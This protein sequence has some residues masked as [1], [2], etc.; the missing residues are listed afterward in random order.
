MR[1]P[2]RS[3][4]KIF[5]HRGPY[6]GDD[7]TYHPTLSDACT[8]QL[9]GYAPVG[10]RRVVSRLAEYH[11]V[12]RYLEYLRQLYQHR[13]TELCVSCFDMTHM[14][15]RYPDLLGKRLLRQTFCCYFCGDSAADTEML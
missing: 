4:S 1:L 2:R 9:L 14:S 15:G 11:A 3:K 7:L 13:Q 8:F 5:I 6:R 12:G 10:N